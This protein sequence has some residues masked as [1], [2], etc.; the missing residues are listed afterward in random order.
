MASPDVT[1]S[2]VIRCRNEA[3]D[4]DGVLATV[5]AQ[6]GGT[7]AE[8]I[9]LD[10]GSTDGTLDLLARRPVRIERLA[11][12][13]TYGRALN[14]GAALSTGDVVVYLSAHARPLD[15]HWLA[16]L[17]APFADERVV[18]TFGAQR[19][20]AGVNPIEAITTR[21]NFPPVPPASVLF[22]TANGA[23]RRPA[24]LARPFD[25][26]IAIAEDHLWA[27]GVRPPTR[28]VYVP[29]AVV[30][31]SHPMTLAHWRQRFYAHGL[32]AAYARGRAHTTLPW[33]DGAPGATR[34]RAGAFLR[35]VGDL[36]RDGEL[37]ALARLPL[38]AYARTRSHARG[39][40]D[41]ARRWGA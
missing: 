19:P 1:V 33:D 6:T 15:E 30:A 23:V 17:I 18:A 26:E 34:S 5:L 8:V 11:E 16:R 39:L 21:R 2:V 32:A 41:G 35:L 37:R 14:R 10:S 28:I 3:R 24:V 29:E 22:S 9:A 31:H 40:R 7:P 13:F 20:I 36:A 25:E 12:A 4:L 27:L 38:Y